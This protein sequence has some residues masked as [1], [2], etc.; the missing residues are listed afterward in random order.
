MIL[1]LK[2][3]NK[4]NQTKQAKQTKQ[5][6]QTNNEINKSDLQNDRWLHVYVVLACT[7]SDCPVLHYLRKNVGYMW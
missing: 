6:K 1:S 2:Q 7:S 3:P 5:T 4:Q